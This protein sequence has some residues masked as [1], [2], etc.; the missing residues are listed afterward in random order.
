VDGRAALGAHHIGTGFSVFLVSR[1]DA[2]R[3]NTALAMGMFGGTLSLAVGIGGAMARNTSSVVVPSGLV[4]MI[5]GSAAGVAAP[6]AL[7]PIFYRFLGYGPNPMIPVMVHSGFYSA[8]GGS[9]GLAFGYGLR[10]WRG[11]A[12]GF[13]AGAMGGV[14]GSILFAMV[15]ALAFPMEWDFSPIPGKGLSRLIAHFC[16]AVL[17]VT[18][19]VL[20]LWEEPARVESEVDPA[21]PTPVSLFDE[22]EA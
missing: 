15:H 4:G 8:I 2:E 12:R 7:V 17:S 5:A 6:W 14:L 1:E 10:G 22:P 16:V 9:A 21:P 18:C 20:A 3:R 11:A 19:A 13:S